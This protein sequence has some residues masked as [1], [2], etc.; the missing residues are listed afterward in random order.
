MLESTDPIAL[1]LVLVAVLLSYLIGRRNGQVKAVREM[2][3]GLNKML[4]EAGVDL[5]I[6]FEKAIK[7]ESDDE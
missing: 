5:A 2:T 6:D 7:G 3:Y 1:V 4:A